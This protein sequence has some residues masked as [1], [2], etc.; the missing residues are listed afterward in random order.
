MGFSPDISTEAAAQA[1]VGLNMEKLR[2]EKARF[3]EAVVPQWD[4]A[5]KAKHGGD[6]Q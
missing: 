5:Y 4:A 3:L 1:A 6:G 2:A